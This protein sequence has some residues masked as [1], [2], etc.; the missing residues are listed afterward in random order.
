MAK[1]LSEMERLSK[2]DYD[3]I[4]NW[5]PEYKLRRVKSQLKEAK[6]FTKLENK[7]YDATKMLYKLCTS[8]TPLLCF[9]VSFAWRRYK[10]SITMLHDVKARS[11]LDN[12]FNDISLGFLG[13]M[14][15]NI[16]CII[17]TYKGRDYVRERLTV[18]KDI[19]FSRRAF[20]QYHSDEL[21][22]DY[23]HLAQYSSNLV[24]DK[25]LEELRRLN[26]DDLEKIRSLKDIH[27][28]FSKDNDSS[29]IMTAEELLKKKKEH[30]LGLNRQDKAKD[31]E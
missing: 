26:T 20:L 22:D 21:L 25:E 5:T 31:R 14:A 3:S 15:G 11:P 10:H 9:T 12:L 27:E 23:S 28:D 24:S 8:I 13:Y 29:R 16:Y 19:K 7:D 30:Q 2:E 17:G 6:K 18:E 1:K 4:P